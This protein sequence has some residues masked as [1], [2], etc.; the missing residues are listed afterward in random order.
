VGIPWSISR[1]IGRTLR[2]ACAAGLCAVALTAPAAASGAGR[3]WTQVGTSV[4]F[5]RGDGTTVAWTEAP[6]RA[7]LAGGGTIGAPPGCPGHVTAAGAGRVLFECRVDA[8]V[9]PAFDWRGDYAVVPDGVRFELHHDSYYDRPSLD[10]IGADW[11]A[12][13]LYGYHVSDTQFRNWHDGWRLLA[14]TGDTFGTGKWLDPSL[15]GLGRPLCRPLRRRARGERFD[16]APAYFPLQVSGRWA[17]DG[18]EGTA[19]LSG[20]PLVL[21]HCGTRRARKLGEGRSGM[22][23]SGWV[24]WIPQTLDGRARGVRALRLRDGRVFT[25]KVDDYAWVVHT[26]DALYASVPLEP[27]AQPGQWRIL[28]APL[29]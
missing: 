20:S 18:T 14:S 26:A 5:A 27:G 1:S 4:G 15:H 21:R 28:R 7:R 9:P 29:P 22:V 2:P 3:E 13:G 8:G 19:L 17:L 25:W 12:G 10:Q 24:T 6:G 23:G 16:T 11:I